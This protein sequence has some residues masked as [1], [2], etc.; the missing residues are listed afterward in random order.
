MSKLTDAIRK[1]FGKIVGL[2]KKY[3][4]H[5]NFTCDICGRE[6]FQNER[7]CERC[8]KNLPYIGRQRC[9]LCGRRVKETGV[10]MECKR[11]PLSVKKAC[12]VFTHER[13]AARLIIRFKRGDRFLYRTLAELAEPLFKREFSDCDVITD[14]P[15]T[16]KAQRKRGYHQTRL[17][18]EEL[19]R[20][21]GIPFCVTAV[22]QRETALQKTLGRDAREKN[23]KGCFRVSDWATVEG[24]KILIVDDTL[25]TGSTVSELAETLIRAGAK[26][27]SAL[28][29][30]SVEH[31]NPF[32]KLPDK[33]NEK[34]RIKEIGIGTKR[35]T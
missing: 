31:K 5:H 33:S 14:V 16:K 3:D 10:C 12:S 23:L 29:I 6:V 32:G 17:L 4:D 21:C 22:K 11:K 19:S 35:S 7:I 34:E 18:A 25:T 2:I 9:T 26:S 27:V 8:N 28:T 24:L 1:Y 20:R 15:M 30:T 13:E